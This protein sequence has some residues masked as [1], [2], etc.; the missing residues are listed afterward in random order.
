MYPFFAYPPCGIGV[1]MLGGCFYRFPASQFST[2]ASKEV[3]DVILSP[4]TAV[5][6]TS[7]PCV[8][9]PIISAYASLSPF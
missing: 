7:M 2:K 9:N 3:L 8:S 4:Q 5:V 1:N 6:G